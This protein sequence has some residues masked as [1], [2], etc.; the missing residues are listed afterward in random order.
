MPGMSP[1]G[2]GGS[3]QGRIAALE[4]ENQALRQA[5]AA[6]ALRLRDREAA[7]THAA[8]GIIIGDA[9]GVMIDVNP[10]LCTLLGFAADELL[11]RHIRDLFPDEVLAVKP[12]RFDLLAEGRVLTTA[13]DMQARDGSRVPIEMRSLRLPD[14][15]HLAFVRD[16]RERHRNL[17]AVQEA[18]RASD[19]QATFLAALLAAIPS[20]VFWKDR[21]GRYQ[22]CNQV[23]CDLLGVTEADLRGRTVH[24][25]WPSDHARVRSEE[26]RVG[27][28]CRSR[29]SPYH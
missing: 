17:A 15:R 1:D 16:V 21:E 3:D 6:G 18:Q 24:E 13:R 20:P 2:S 4:A 5:L 12:L 8:D 9:A 23:F 28:E 14:G 29:W 22:G 27:K 26:R 19:R 7:F 25:V 10:C 11:G